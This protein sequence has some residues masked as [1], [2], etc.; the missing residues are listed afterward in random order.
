MAKLE[1]RRW[2]NML[3]MA[4]V[5]N[6]LSD[7]EIEFLS[8]ISINLGISFDD[9]NKSMEII[10]SGRAQLDSGVTLFEQRETLKD[11]ICVAVADGDMGSPEKKAISK[12]AISLGME[13]PE[14]DS[15]IEVCRKWVGTHNY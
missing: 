6:V 12:V 5:D 9:M 10:L 13:T 11:I 2:Q 7:S 1:L 15:L 14:I 4:F 3:T 8:K